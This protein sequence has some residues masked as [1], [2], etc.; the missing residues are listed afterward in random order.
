MFQECI[1]V[2]Q[3]HQARQGSGFHLGPFLSCAYARLHDMVTSDVSS[4][5]SS[6]QRPVTAHLTGLGLT[7]SLG[8]NS[9]GDFEGSTDLMVLLLPQLFARV[10]VILSYF[11]FHINTDECNKQLVLITVICDVLKAH[12]LG[13]LGFSK[14]LKPDLYNC[15]QRWYMIPNVVSPSLCPECFPSTVLT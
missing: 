4:W 10:W 15:L 5:S 6:G 9:C 7:K 8:C 13:Q 11:F 2:Q 3:Q 14:L 1:H 12:G